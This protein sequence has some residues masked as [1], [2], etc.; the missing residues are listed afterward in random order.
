MDEP[1]LGGVQRYLY[2]AVLDGSLDR[3]QNILISVEPKKVVITF[4]FVLPAIIFWFWRLSPDYGHSWVLVG[5][6]PI[7]F[8]L[9]VV[10]LFISLALGMKK[11]DLSWWLSTLVN[12]SV[13]VITVT[14]IFRT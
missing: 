8:L 2:K 13:I 6:M 5:L 3:L 4:L 9:S 7:L 1:V 10:F 14:D 11:R 12:G